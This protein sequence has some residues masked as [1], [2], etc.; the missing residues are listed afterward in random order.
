MNCV[1]I[2]K[3][4]RYIYIRCKRC[5]TVLVSNDPKLSLA[6]IKDNQLIGISSCEHFK[7]I[8]TDDGI[9]IVSRES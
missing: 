6:S 2:E 8:E 5:G 7:I 4:G 3:K 1:E 9:E